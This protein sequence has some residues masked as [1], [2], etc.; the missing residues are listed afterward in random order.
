MIRTPLQGVLTCVLAWGLALGC[1]VEVGGPEEAQPPEEAPAAT[2]QALSSAD[3]WD[4]DYG[5]GLS[6]EVCISRS[7]DCFRMRC[8]NGGNAQYC[9]E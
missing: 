6:C 2:A 4:L 5:G 1:A 7:G 8:S 3:C 9:A